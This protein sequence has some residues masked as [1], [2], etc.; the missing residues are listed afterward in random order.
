M[1]AA[2]SLRAAH[3]ICRSVG[4]TPGSVPGTVLALSHC[5]LGHAMPPVAQAPIW[6]R[7]AYIAGTLHVGP[8]IVGAATA[9]TPEECA[10]MCEATPPCKWW[11]HCRA[12]AAG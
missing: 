7:W 3:V 1:C 4:R 9:L 10:E 6:A 11:A 12:D 8:N 5:T 2:A